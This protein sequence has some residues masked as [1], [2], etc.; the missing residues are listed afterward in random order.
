M[1]N[2][3][4]YE[5]FLNENMMDKT[6][7]QIMAMKDMLMEIYN[8]CL[9]HGKGHL[10][11]DDFE[12]RIQDLPSTGKGGLVLAV[13]VNEEGED[14]LCPMW[15]PDAQGPAAMQGEWGDLGV[16]EEEEEDYE[17]EEE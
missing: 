5:S 16:Y 13:G 8:C 10:F 7:M 1:N 6:P 12:G 3:K 9:S 14:A 17:E 2:L 15:D 11:C 4:H